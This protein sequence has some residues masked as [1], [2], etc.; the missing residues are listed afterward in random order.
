MVTARRFGV[1]RV[2]WVRLTTDDW[3]LTT[4]F[5]AMLRKTSGFKISA[6]Q[7]RLC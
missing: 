1:V 5:H 3:L 2:V 4:A 7:D 6:E